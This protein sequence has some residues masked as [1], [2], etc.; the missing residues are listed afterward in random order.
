[1]SAVTWDYGIT[2]RPP[3]APSSPCWQ[4]EVVRHKPVGLGVPELYQCDGWLTE[5]ASEQQVAESTLQADMT[6]FFCAW[7]M[8]QSARVEAVCTRNGAY[9]HTIIFHS[10][11]CPPRLSWFDWRAHKS[12]V[13]EYVKTRCLPHFWSSIFQNGAEGGLWVIFQRE[14]MRHWDI[15]RP[16]GS[17]HCRLPDL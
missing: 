7:I 14:C 15:L 11:G 17:R 2:K 10:S 3:S 16:L 12:G 5:P 9:M 6:R 13:G 4:S 1:M 8:Q